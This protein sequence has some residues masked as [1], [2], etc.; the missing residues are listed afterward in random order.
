MSASFSVLDSAEARKRLSQLVESLEQQ[1]E[2]QLF[3]RNKAAITALVGGGGL[4]LLALMAHLPLL[5]IP[6]A[7]FALL[8]V[9]R[10]NTTSYTAYRELFKATVIPL[11]L[12][13]MVQGV[14]Y[15]PRYKIADGDIN[16]GGLFSS[17]ECVFE[18][19]DL[20]EGVIGQTP[21]QLCDLRVARRRETE[22][23]GYPFRPGLGV[24]MGGLGSLVG[25]GVMAAG[26]LASEGVS[27][28]GGN[29][30]GLYMIA[31]FH[32]SFS[33]R[34][35]VLPDVAEKSVGHLAGQGMQR[36]NSRYGELIVME[37]PDFER[38]FVVY[39]S[40]QVESRYLLTT[41][42]MQRI[43]RLKQRTRS[44]LSMAFV[45]NRVHLALR[46]FG[47]ILEVDLRES[48]LDGKAVERIYGQL[49]DCLGLV[50][51]LNLNTRIWSKAADSAG[52]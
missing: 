47:D 14:H 41:S 23:E 4:G 40:D 7:V 13:E 1:R 29:F 44:E 11:L 34:T 30:N 3:K 18:G 16:G 6:V 46:N 32:K 43:L 25:L 24:R 51:E 12:R 19:E 50:D 52:Q 17:G 27:L 33:G 2:A 22:E 21:F 38:E 10:N 5:V 42:L 26:K 28:Q 45:D 31:D 20:I 15:Q 48:L 37:N 9:T 35:V 49:H 8:L 36:R 39:G